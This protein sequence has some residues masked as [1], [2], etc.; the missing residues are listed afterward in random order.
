M[1]TLEEYLRVGIDER[2]TIDYAIRAFKD[3]G[4]NI[5]FWIH[6]DKKDG[7]TLTMKVTG[8]TLE[9]LHATNSY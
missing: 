4:G 7:Q 2:E 6:P 3:D 8:N 9:L 5:T 1:K